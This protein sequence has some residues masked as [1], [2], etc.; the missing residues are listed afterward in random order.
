MTGPDPAPPG[1]RV[2]GTMPITHRYTPGIAGERFFRALAEDGVFLAT[3]CAACGIT[4][5]PA[6][7]FCERCFAELDLDA[8]VAVGPRGTLISATVV[9]IDLAGRPL[10]EPVGV[11]LVRLDGADT[12]LLHRLT[13][14]AAALGLG[15]AVE[16]VL[17]PAA[18]RVGALG[19][20][21]AFRPVPG[22]RPPPA[23]VRR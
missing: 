16:A 11:G 12:V 8:A 9:H 6:R 13:P 17:K 7:I 1:I 3:R 15:E 23:A 4:Y 21:I 14:E 5:C 22:G 18:E 19:D 2:S 20:V 10:P